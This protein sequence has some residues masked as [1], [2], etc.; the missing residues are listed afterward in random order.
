MFGML[1]GKDKGKRKERKESERQEEGGGTR[2][3]GVSRSRR[4]TGEGRKGNAKRRRENNV[5]GVGGRRRNQ[6][7]AI[8]VEVGK[9]KKVKNMRFYK[10][11]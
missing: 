9:D 6:Q 8:E 3:M 4:K 1:A 7:E 10:S 11:V 5:Q 2:C